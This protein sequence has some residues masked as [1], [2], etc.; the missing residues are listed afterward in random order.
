MYSTESFTLMRRTFTHSAGAGIFAGT[1]E[2]VLPREASPSQPLLLL[3]ST[4]YNKPGVCG[5]G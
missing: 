4:R 2:I 1:P 3:R 5:Q